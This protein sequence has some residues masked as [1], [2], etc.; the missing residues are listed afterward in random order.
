[1]Q[2]QMRWDDSL[3]IGI[4]IIDQQ[5]KE[6]IAYINQLH[7]VVRASDGRDSSAINE[8]LSGLINYTET[9]FAYEEELLDNLN[10]P[11]ANDH[12]KVHRAFGQRMRDYQERYLM[13][14]DVVE[15]LLTELQ[16]WLRN[17]IQSS[18]Q[19]YARHCDVKKDSKTFL[20]RALGKLLN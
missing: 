7:D 4:N 17:H 2:T 15:P 11:F 5:H 12:K 14:E 10:Y 8:V 16:S 1:M 18:D 3:E 6:I 20:R 13:G 19:H 9:H